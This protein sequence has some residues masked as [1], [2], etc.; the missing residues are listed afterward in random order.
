MA[1]GTR[2]GQTIVYAAAADTD[3]DEHFFIKEWRWVSG[4]N[5]TPQLL[6]VDSKGSR[7]AKSEGD[8]AEFID[9][10]RPL[11]WFYGIV[12]TTLTDGDFTVVVG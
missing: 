6:V 8:Q 1:V 11:A 9:S 3:P 12:I 4:V 10:G 2:N 7:I 5:A